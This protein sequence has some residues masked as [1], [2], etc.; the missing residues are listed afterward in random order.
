[1]LLSYT[2]GYAYLSSVKWLGVIMLK[3]QMCIVREEHWAAN[4]NHA[5]SW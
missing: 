1:M 2:L 3:I 5:K 4:Q